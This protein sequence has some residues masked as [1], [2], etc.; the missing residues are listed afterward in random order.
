MVQLAGL[1]E[2]ARPLQS[3]QYKKNL[4]LKQFDYHTNGYYFI[5][6]NADFSRP[7]I[8]SGIKT[9]VKDH[10]FDLQRRFP[11]VSIYYYALMPTHI[12]VIL[13]LQN[14]QQTVPEI[15][16]VFKS[17]TTVFARKTGFKNP[18]LWQRNYFEHVIRNEKA[19]E[20]IVLYMRNNPFK[21]NI[22]LNEMYGDRIPNLR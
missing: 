17:I 20:A 14:S 15:W 16:R 1:F 18:H 9:L 11:G 22:P 2:Q 10:L 3:M 19:L 8:V 4:R 6:N 12:H 13:Y 5:T 21:E 7:Y